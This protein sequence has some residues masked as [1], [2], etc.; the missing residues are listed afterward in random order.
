MSI[1][2][3]PITPVV[4]EAGKEEIFRLLGEDEPEEKPIEI[5]EPE[6]KEEPEKEEEEP[7]KKEEVEEV[8]ELKEIEEELEGPD[9]EKLELTT[10][11]RR[12]EILAKYPNLFK[13]FPYLE[14]AYY[15]EQALT[16]IVPTI[17]DAKTAVSKAET[18]DQFETDLSKGN[19]EKALRAAKS[20][21]DDAFSSLVDNYLPNLAK[22][23]RD[24]YHH[25]VGNVIR[26]TVIGMINEAKSSN[27]TDME[28]AARILNRYVFATNQVTNP[29]LLSKP[30]AADGKDPNEEITKREQELFKQRFE[31]SRDSL[32]TKISNVLKA[33]ID[34]NIDPKDSMTAYIKKTASKECVDDLN[35][36]LDGD[37]RLRTII[38]RLWEQ[39][40][41]ENFS[42][43]SLDKIKSAYLSVAKTLLP[44]VIKKARNEA[45]KGLGKRIREDEDNS[46]QKGPVSVGRSTSSSGLSGKTDR[47]KARAIPAGITSRDFLMQD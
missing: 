5:K 22:V 45:L 24:A 3:E 8:D 7:E 21:G 4:E 26:A 39:S 33:T 35:R 27:D 23:D 30:K 34:A 19:L 16:E 6:K 17:E 25:V 32:N 1:P 31:E 14:R 41:K 43:T 40:A 20:Y 13:D 9:E 44:T 28:E 11:V 10:P 12:R 38:D 47:E 2:N 29:S 42:K 18:L 36:L 46:P 37:R 15:R